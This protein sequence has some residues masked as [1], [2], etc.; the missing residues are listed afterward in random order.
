M[1]GNIKVRVNLTKAEVQALIKQIFEEIELDP[2]KY[3]DQN[4]NFNSQAHQ[5]SEQATYLAL[6]KEDKRI[7]KEI[8]D[9]RKAYRKNLT[10]FIWH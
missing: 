7:A 4:K 10:I 8:I 2:S 1:M 9:S 6:K 5:H 3:L